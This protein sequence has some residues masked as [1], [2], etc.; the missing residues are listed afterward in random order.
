MDIR[1]TLR[2]THDIRNCITFV[3]LKL[4]CGGNSADTEQTSEVHGNSWNSILRPRNY[5][6]CWSQEWQFDRSNSSEH[7]RMTRHNIRL[8]YFQIWMNNF[9][10]VINYRHGE[11]TATLGLWFILKSFVI[12]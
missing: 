2:G 3:F 5:V 1:E 11:G 6:R 8:K 12:M 9:V 10:C 7:R 4:F